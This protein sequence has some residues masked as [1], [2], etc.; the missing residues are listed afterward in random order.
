MYKLNTLA[1]TKIPSPGTDVKREAFVYM[2]HGTYYGISLFKL[3]KQ[4]KYKD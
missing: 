2:L 1:W 4:G 3:E